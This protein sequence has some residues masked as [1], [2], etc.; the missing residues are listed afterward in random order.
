M[1]LV[2]TSN[3]DFFVGI[4]VGQIIGYM[5]PPAHCVNQDKKDKGG[6]KWITHLY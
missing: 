1:S 5:T 4:G 3:L 2:Q 6:A